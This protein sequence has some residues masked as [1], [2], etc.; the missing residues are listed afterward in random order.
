MLLL[1]VCATCEGVGA[2]N[3]VHVYKCVLYMYVMITHVHVCVLVHI[4]ECNIWTLV[5]LGVSATCV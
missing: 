3:L 1:G 2:H 4:Y 5:Y